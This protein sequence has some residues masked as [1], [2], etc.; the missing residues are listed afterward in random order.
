VADILFE[1]V[2]R[3]Q[4][5]DD[6]PDQGVQQYQEI[7]PQETDLSRQED[8]QVMHRIFE[9]HGG[10]PGKQS[11]AYAQDQYQPAVAQ[12]AV[13]ESLQATGDIL[14]IHGTNVIFPWFFNF[15]WNGFRGVQG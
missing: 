5:H 7:K 2:T 10:Y 6:D 13:A 4:I 12:S 8:P 3:Q 15:A 14:K 9:D 11:G 1:P